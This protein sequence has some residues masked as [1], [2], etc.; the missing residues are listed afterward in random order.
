ML[1]MAKVVSKL[2]I[3]GVTDKD[4]FVLLTGYNFFRAPMGDAT[5]PEN[6]AAYKAAWQDG[7]IRE[8]VRDLQTKRIR[9]KPIWSVRKFGDPDTNTPPVPVPPG[10]VIVKYLRHTRAE[11]VTY[12]DGREDLFLFGGSVDQMR[13]VSNKEAELLTASGDAVMVPDSEAT[14]HLEYYG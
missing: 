7:A 10:T 11:R 14:E 2:A 13:R 5:V 8:R 6:Y 4:L 9:I 12:D 1:E 3:R